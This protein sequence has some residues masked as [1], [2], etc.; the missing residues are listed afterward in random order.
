M[1]KDTP[2]LLL[3]AVFPLLTLGC[4]DTQPGGAISLIGVDA[5]PPTA[6]GCETFDFDGDGLPNGQDPDG[7]NDGVDNLFDDFPDDP[8][9]ASQNAFNCGACGQECGLDETCV[10]GACT[11]RQDNSDVSRTDNV[12]RQEPEGPATERPRDHEGADDAHE[13]EAHESE[14][15]IPQ[16]EAEEAPRDEDD[17][18][19][20][21]DHGDEEA[22]REGDDHGGEEDATTDP[23]ADS[24]IAEYCD[25]EACMAQSECALALSC[26][27]QCS[28][29][30]CI[31]ACIE[32]APSS[33]TNE[34]SFAVSCGLQAGCFTPPA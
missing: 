14:T 20:W 2:S 15:V 12:P 18:G 21:D 16:E 1:L 9:C 32:D 24:C 34:L 8:N 26:I 4:A 6:A 23:I 25:V 29:E 3:L 33:Y 7:D 5:C 27:V 28:T 13:G 10:M 11:D 19:D 17:H 22:P 31:V 30:S